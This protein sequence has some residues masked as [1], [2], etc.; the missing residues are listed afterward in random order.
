MQMCRIFVY[1]SASLA[2][3]A[4]IPFKYFMIFTPVVMFLVLLP[5]SLAGIGLRE[6][7]YVYFFT[8]IGISASVAFA[9]SAL[10]SII[11]VLSVLPGGL[12]LGILGLAL[13]KEPVAVEKNLDLT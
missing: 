10:V 8:K 6:G 9:T 5:I 3:N 7:S 12:I 11:V 13:K 4:D 2:V 1:Y